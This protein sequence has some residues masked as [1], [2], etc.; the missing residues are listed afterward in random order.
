[1]YVTPVCPIMCTV[2]RVTFPD[3][4]QHENDICKATDLGFTLLNKNDSEI[5]QPVIFKDEMTPRNHKVSSIAI[6]AHKTSTRSS[7]EF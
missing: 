4:C 2:S 3:A 7:I 6:K 5:K 1:M